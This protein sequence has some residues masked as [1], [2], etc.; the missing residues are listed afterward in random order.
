M[1]GTTVAVAT[2]AVSSNLRMVLMS[3]PPPRRKSHGGGA[4]HSV[5]RRP[6]ERGSGRP[7]ALRPPGFPGVA[8]VVGGEQVSQI[9]GTTQRGLEFLILDAQ[10][11]RAAV[12]ERRRD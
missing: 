4:P 1:K 12:R 11:L 10:W 7:V 3:R 5:A 9:I 2:A 6:W 8:V